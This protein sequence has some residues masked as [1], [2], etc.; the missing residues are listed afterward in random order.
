M[1]KHE[2]ERYICLPVSLTRTPW[3]LAQ[4]TAMVIVVM[5]MAVAKCSSLNGVS[6]F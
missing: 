3:A 1:S 2:T 4:W 6:T 5:I